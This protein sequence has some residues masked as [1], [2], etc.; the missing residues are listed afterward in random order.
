M[1]ITADRLPRRLNGRVRR[2][3]D[4]SGLVFLTGFIAATAAISQ[5][6][7]P[8][9]AQPEI[10]DYYDELPTPDFTPP[11]RAQAVIWPAAW[12]LMGL[13]GWRVWRA[14][15]GED[16][17]KA[18]GAFRFSLGMTAGFFKMAFGN[19][20]TT[21]A[22]VD[23]LG[24]TVASALYTLFANRV[25]RLAGVLAAPYTGWLAFTTVI[26]ALTVRRLR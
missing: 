15:E 8:T 14:R 25:D 22:A 9:P 10:E 24:V 4:I 5:Y 6:Y 23:M 17:D 1:T 7:A 2:D 19:R 16:R 20:K 21:G 12:V 26:A 13:S 18:L 11:P 3:R